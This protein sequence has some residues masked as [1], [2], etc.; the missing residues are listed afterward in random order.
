MPDQE[1]CKLCE[2][3]GEVSVATVS[4][5]CQHEEYPCPDC[6]AREYA[7]LEAENVRLRGIWVEARDA[8]IVTSHE[9]ARLREALQLIRDG[10]GSCQCER[11]RYTRCARCLSCEAL[12]ATT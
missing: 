4:G 3:S 6:G 7:A 11:R 12:E 2:G 9:N 5:G 1:E 10:Y 8:V